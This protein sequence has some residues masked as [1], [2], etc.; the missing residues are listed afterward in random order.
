MSTSDT[1]TEA[2]IAMAEA[3]A[4]G[5]ETLE[6][7][8]QGRAS[9]YRM[10]SRLFLK[11]LTDE[12]IEGLVA[13]D[14]I[15]RAQ[16][17]GDDSLLAEGLNDMGRGLNKRNTGTRQTLGTDYTMCFGAMSAVNSEVA[18]PYAS[19]FLGE[20]AELYQKPRNDVLMIYSSEGISLKEKVDLPEDHLAFE[21]E[22][23]A[24]LSERC[25]VALVDDDLAE[26]RR[27]LELSR[28]FMHEQ[29]LTWI[30]LLIE[31]ANQLLTTRFYRGLMKATRGYL[32]LD[33]E[34]ID[35]ILED[36]DK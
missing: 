36:L 27:N 6:S 22:F 10:F 24:V 8:F 31:R 1:K 5:A 11:P 25:I 34:T 30:D 26:V 23:L 4:E 28:T 17:I 15:A 9:S 2:E 12:D 33:L 18:A 29:I 20:E 13:M 3:E 19:V 35:E 7:V 21:L 16:S 32:D 14:L